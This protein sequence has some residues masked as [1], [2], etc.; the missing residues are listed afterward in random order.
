MSLLGNAFVVYKYYRLKT[1]GHVNTLL[2]DSDTI[3]KSSA[4]SD[5][6]ADES[7]VKQLASRAGD[8]NLKI[9][10]IGN[11]L[12]I[13]PIADYWW[14]EWGMAASERD[15]DYV[16]VV[17]NCF[18]EYV[19]TS[20][21]ACNF[22][23]WETMGHDRAETLPLL[24]SMI[25]RDDD[26][27]VI[28]LGENVRDTATLKKDYVELFDYCK[29]KSP[30]AEIIVVDNFW[31]SFSVENA[32]DKACAE[33]AIQQVDLNDLQGIKDYQCGL[34]TEVS[35]NNGDIHKVEHEGVASHPGDK[36]MEEIGQRIL[37]AIGSN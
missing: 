33:S 31:T 2:Y 5:I 1:S 11:S 23:S 22:A 9:L 28:Q 10:F 18:S 17:V 29:S 19:D 25:S 27:I 13:H 21:V 24:D 14:G 35:G 20:Y 36:G 6:T 3:D 37:N 16:H 15:K 12:T 8:D 34:E 26:L 32:K 4:V 30:N 7:A